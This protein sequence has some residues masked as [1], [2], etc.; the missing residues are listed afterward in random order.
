MIVASWFFLPATIQFRN[1]RTSNWP[2][3]IGEQFEFST[4]INVCADSSASRIDLTNLSPLRLC[5][6]KKTESRRFCRRSMSAAIP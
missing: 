5:G 2:V 1:A 6:E 3:M 4:Q